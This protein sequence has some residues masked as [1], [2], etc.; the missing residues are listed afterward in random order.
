MP[1]LILAVAEDLDE[2]FQ[3]SRVTTITPLRELCR[4][5]VMAVYVFLVFVVAIL[6]SEDGWADRT[7]KMFDVVF[8]IEGGDIRP[9]ESATT[10]IA[11]EIKASK[12]IRLAKGVLSIAIVSVDREEFRRDDVTTVL[13]VKRRKLALRK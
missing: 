7:G 8:A 6:R 9:A 11:E 13:F 5:M 2:L 12:V 4:V 10:I 1:V 3:D